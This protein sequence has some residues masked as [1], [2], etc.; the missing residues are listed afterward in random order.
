MSLAIDTDN[1]EL[2]EISMG[3]IGDT[4]KPISDYFSSN[5]VHLHWDG[6]KRR[7]LL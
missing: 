6:I 3:W 2:N 7:Q 5:L 1:E 4:V